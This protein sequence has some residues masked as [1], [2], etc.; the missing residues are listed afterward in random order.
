MRKQASLLQIVHLLSELIVFNSY[1]FEEFLKK[2][3][4]LILN[5]I[6]VD[7]C[8]IYFFD[9]SEREFILIASKKP[10]AKLMGK[11]KMKKGEGITGW[12]AEHQKTVAIAK[13]AYTDKRFKLVK[14]LP[15]DRYEAFLS[16]PIFDKSGVVGVINLQN[17]APYT[18]SKEEIRIVE[19]VV[20]MVSS[21]FQ[22]ILLEKQVSSLEASIAD[23]K[24]IDKAKGVLMAKDGLTE[25]QAYELLR[26]EAMRKR[27][28]K[29][30]IADAVLLVWG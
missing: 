1:N 10:H 30:E 6:P 20:T 13:E 4:R 26:K 28:S 22:K 23:R 17:I 19:A 14:E 12:V 3:I 29:R 8:L 11:I 25:K 15:E 18:F 7:S 27:K 5:I 24:I 16:V 2:L 9:S 21:A